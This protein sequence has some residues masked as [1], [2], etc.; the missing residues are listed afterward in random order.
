MSSEDLENQNEQTL[1]VEEKQVSESG[2]DSEEEYNEE[3][4]IKILLASDTHL[5]YNERHSIQGNDSFSSFEEILQIGKQKGVD[6]ILH[7]G[8]LFN[9]NKPSRSTLYR[10]VKLLKKYC[11]GSGDIKF[12]IFS[13]QEINF[14]SSK[15]V[16]FE[17]PNLNVR[18]PIFMIHGNH[19]DPSGYESLSINDVLGVTGLVNYYGKCTDLDDIQI[20]PIIITKNKTK[21]LLY[22]LGYIRDERL[23]RNFEQNK[24]TFKRPRQ[25]ADDWFS[26]FSIHQNRVHHSRKNLV[27]EEQLPDWLDF[28][29]WGHEHDCQIVPQRSKNGN[30]YIVQTGS[31]V[32]TSLSEL[33]KVQKQV[34]ILTIRGKN[35]KIEAIPLENVRNFMMKD[36]QL[37]N[38]EEL[39]GKEKNLDFI[40]KFIERNVNQMINECKI[41]H[42]QKQRQFRIRKEKYQQLKLEEKKRKKEKK[43]NIQEEEKEEGESDESD[44]SDDDDDDDDEDEKLYPLKNPDY[45]LIRLKVEYTGFEVPTP[46]RFGQRFV[47]KVANPTNLLRIYCKR[48][49]G[50]KSAEGSNNSNINLG[51]GEQSTEMEGFLDQNSVPNLIR[52]Y[53]QKSSLNNN[54]NNKKKNNENNNEINLEEQNSKSSLLVLSESDLTNAV[55]DYVEKHDKTSIT[56]LIE[57]TR[58][59]SVD[60]ILQKINQEGPLSEKEIKYFL[61]RRKISLDQV[62]PTGN[63][64]NEQLE[65]TEEL[66]RVAQEDDFGFNPM[67]TVL[68]NIDSIENRGNTQNNPKQ[69]SRKNKQQFGNDEEDDFNFNSDDDDDDGDD[70]QDIEIENPFGK[71]N[72]RA[73]VKKRK[74]L[75][76]DSENDENDF[77]D[78]EN[79]TQENSIL[80][81]KKYQN[82]N[83]KGSDDDEMNME[84]TLDDDNEN[85]LQKDKK[86]KKGEKK[87]KKKR[88]R[89]RERE[90]KRER[91][92]EKGKSKKKSKKTEKKDMTTKEE[93]SIKTTNNLKEEEQE[94]KEEKSQET[95]QIKNEN[96]KESTKTSK[97]KKRSSKKKEKTKTKTKTKKTSNKK[98]KEIE[99]K[100]IDKGNET[101]KEKETET[102]TETKT[103]KET[104][105]EKE[106]QDEKE[107]E[108][109]KSKKEQQ[110][111]LRKKKREEKKKLENM[112]N[113]LQEGV[114]DCLQ[115]QLLLGIED[116][117]LLEK[118]NKVTGEK[119][120]QIYNDTQKTLE[121]LSSLEE[122]KSKFEPYI[123]EANQIIKQMDDLETIVDELDDFS[124]TLEKTFNEILTNEEI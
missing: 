119:Y 118:M 33:E 14:P 24:V 97:K 107:K 35:F 103:E 1:N 78:L 9:S 89:E 79:I 83:N 38:F 22:G 34:A 122:K 15:S 57:K 8:D 29:L 28:V 94:T 32:A 105:P 60:F 6:F 91:K 30:S 120:D 11:L 21:V 19:D 53:I 52:L 25:G 96:L 64:N 2:E 61:N 62:V 45:P 93:K 58:K 102:E 56:D 73:H 44:E 63:I 39:V 99:K 80:N 88:G 108:K 77:I 13:N 16:N 23:H 104:K 18:T 48:P 27:E 37:S 121:F 41:L 95:K 72:K 112:T 111:E 4:E 101:E 12:D 7:G 68:N 3:D 100:N 116:F 40:S 86:N 85:N 47:G 51:I 114:L 90:R 98:T 71:S 81:N 84:I 92:R 17:D 123:E 110:K 87:K 67:Q 75:Y 31:S 117:V 115:K 106:K 50:L 55:I 74:T 46:Q 124:I 36:V 82:N 10:T 109:P 43:H 113:Q 49:T 70:D 69:L 66:E 20:N 26:I 5:G 59:E 65:F 54:F 76:E 42:Q